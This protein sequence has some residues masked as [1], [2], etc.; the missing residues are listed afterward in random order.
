MINR[1]QQPRGQLDDRWH[2]DRGDARRRLLGLI[3]NACIQ[4]VM[5][6]M[7]WP[8]R[9]LLSIGMQR[10]SITPP[11]R[12][13]L[14]AGVTNHDDLRHGLHRHAPGR[15]GVRADH[16]IAVLK[17]RQDTADRKLLVLEGHARLQIIDHRV[18]ACRRAVLALD[19]LLDAHRHLEVSPRRSEQDDLC[20]KLRDETCNDKRAR[21]MDLVDPSAR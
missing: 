7:A 15:A 1:I 10:C 4:S 2:L 19:V 20:S 12:D 9:H 16:E 13:V 14:D 8:T 18:Q 21:G 11:T 3:W 17:L 5:K 6:A